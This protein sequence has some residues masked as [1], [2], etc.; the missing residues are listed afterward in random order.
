MIL[1]STSLSCWLS[2]LN[3]WPLDT[4][5]WSDTKTLRHLGIYC[6]TAQ[7]VSQLL[8]NVPLS[9]NHWPSNKVDVTLQRNSLYLKISS[10]KTLKL[11]NIV[12][13]ILRKLLKILGPSFL[14]LCCK[15]T[16]KYCKE[17]FY[18]ILFFNRGRFELGIA[19]MLSKLSNW[20]GPVN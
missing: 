20:A 15:M 1:L 3:F 18:F 19:M 10:N 2:I 12:H 8:I 11:Y 14:E 6:I 17:D 16:I 5:K 7:F 13:S 9:W 4:W